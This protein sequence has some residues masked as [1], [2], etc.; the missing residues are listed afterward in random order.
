MLT[1]GQ[2]YQPVPVPFWGQIV[3][4]QQILE[5]IVE[6]WK[7]LGV[8]RPEIRDAGHRELGSRGVRLV[9]SD[10]TGCISTQR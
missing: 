1:T 8:S 5:D 2:F 4:P 10:S 7:S 6:L 9:D 3:T